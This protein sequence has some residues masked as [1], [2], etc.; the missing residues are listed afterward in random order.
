MDR[1]LGHFLK[2]DAF[3]HI[4]LCIHGKKTLTKQQTSELYPSLYISSD[5]IGK[6]FFPLSTLFNLPEICLF[7]DLIENLEHKNA[8]LRVSQASA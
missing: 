1:N 3:G 2:I 6:R 7:A 8:P 5:Q 4:A